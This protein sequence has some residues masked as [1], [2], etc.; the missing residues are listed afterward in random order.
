MQVICINITVYVY[1]AFYYKRNIFTVAGSAGF[2]GA[3]T[4]QWNRYKLHLVSSGHV[5]F[6]F[7][8]ALSSAVIA[9][10]ISGQLT[11]LLPIIVCVII[12]NLVAQY[13]GPSIYESYKTKKAALFTTY[14]S[15]EFINT[16]YFCS[17]FYAAWYYTV[18]ALVLVK[19]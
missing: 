9:F 3:N 4:G 8:G 13:L 19:L 15:T 5:A 7:V 6:V 18:G 11:H 14:Y 12:A 2:A 10:E 16:S 1:N 17:R